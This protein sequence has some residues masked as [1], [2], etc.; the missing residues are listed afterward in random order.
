MSVKET[1]DGGIRGDVPVHAVLARV[2]LEATHG[3]DEVLVQYNGC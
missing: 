1:R 3:F 2:P